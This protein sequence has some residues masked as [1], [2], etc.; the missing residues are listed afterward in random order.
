MDNTDNVFRI[1]LDL[2]TLQLIG[3]QIPIDD[4]KVVIDSVEY[5]PFTD[6]VQ[7]Y[8]SKLGTDSWYLLEIPLP[9]PGTPFANY[10]QEIGKPS[11]SN[12]MQLRMTIHDVEATQDTLGI[13]AINFVGNRF[14]INED[15]LVPRLEETIV[16]DTLADE[17]VIPDSLLDGKTALAAI[18]PTYR[19]L[20]ELNSINTILNNE[21]YPPPSVQA[22]LDK[23]NRSGREQDFTAQESAVRLRYRDLQKGYEGWAL[24]AENNQQSYLDYASMSFFVNGRQGPYDPK[25]IFFIR[26]GR[27]ENNFY[28]YS[29][30]VDTGWAEITVP[31][32]DFLTLKEELQNGLSLKGIQSFNGDFKRGSYRI[33]G[34]PTLTKITIMAL[35]V[36]NEDYDV[37]IS[38]EVWV[39]DVRLTDVIKEFGLNGRVQ[40]DA[41]LSDLG[42]VNISISG[43]DN[44]FRN[45]NESIPT[46]SQMDYSM[47]SSVNLDRFAPDEWGLRL[48]VT[49]RHTFKR[50]TPR[51][52]PGSEDVTIQTQESKQ[53][54]KTESKTNN[55]SLSYSKSRGTSMLSR[56][57]LDK[58]TG[59]INYSTTSNLAPKNLSDNMK[60]SG[61][62]NYRADLPRGAEAG[63]FPETFLNIVEWVPLPYFL[64]HNTLTKGLADAK[65]RYM[66][67]DF[68]LSSTTNYNRNRRYDPISG[69]AKQDSTFTVDN[70]FQ[71]RYNPFV[72][73]QT[74]YSID[75][76]RNF[77]EKLRGSKF[78][79]VDIGN[80]INRSQNV[81]LQVAPKAMPWLQ[82][83]YRYT[84]AYTN[85]HSATSA[86]THSSYDDVRDFGLN[87]Q[88][89]INLRFMLP[90]FRKSLSG[91]Q[92]RDP[93]RPRKQEESKDGEDKSSSSAYK[94]AP[95]PKSAGSSGDGIFSRFLF[96][97]VNNFLDN[98]DPFSVQLS[99]THNDKWNNM[100]NNPSF[101]YQIGLQDVDMETRLRRLRSDST[102]IDTAN[103]Q[104]FTWGYTRAYQT[105]MRLF[106]VT[107]LSATYLQTG[108]NSHTINGFTFNRQEGPEFTFDYSNVYIPGFMIGIISRVDL[109]SSYELNNGFRANSI[110][111]QDPV[112]G[113][114]Y[115][116]EQRLGIEAW[117]REENWRPLIRVNAS[118]GATGNIRTVY[119]KNS[120]ITRE[121]KVETNQNQ[122]SETND[123]SFNLQ[124]SFS[125]PNGIRLPFLK[126]IKL[127]SNVRT[128]LDVQ[129]KNNR[130]Y[131]QTLDDFGNVEDEVSSRDTE[132]LSV[133]P[134]LSYDFAQVIGSLSARYNTLK[135]K[136][137]GTKRTTISMTVK[138]QLDF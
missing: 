129:Q 67:N 90:Q 5:D 116:K 66:P 99:R 26:I 110:K 79:G 20:V 93:S 138:I 6:Q 48:P 62:I 95:K 109:T 89:N 104:S 132:E 88:E 120:G 69:I 106:K 17:I 13:A 125:A 55:V 94:R 135:D 41:Q 100:Q 25:P 111:M 96:N 8:R 52:H 103:F 107:R 24:K 73:V 7:Q 53:A 18:T 21:Y 80:E 19:G 14:K 98:F 97:P 83:T 134:T 35:G 131:V 40:V 119:T 86:Y 115:T 56:V 137:N 37:P 136:K 30:P 22:T 70:G 127:Q 101:L 76:A 51:F 42:R 124:Y 28:E 112:E 47:G 133:T 87:R 44:K 31:F 38:G 12:I 121:W 84:A 118:W 91:I 65:V 102:I 63:V 54:F 128:S 61:R 77:N 50:T 82:P 123:N 43:R 92:F 113:E 78:L 11:L 72:S 10:Y 34:N 36:A 49:Y 1:E 122:M 85:N 108:N 59:S 23:Y 114:P 2:R 57:L 39:N 4:R 126:S 46:S 75:V 74:N 105:G 3:D 58:V 15:G 29:V 60:V 64:K 45:L 81:Q 130:V 27:D 9:K 16:L 33:K 71:F 117:T 32:Q 68:E